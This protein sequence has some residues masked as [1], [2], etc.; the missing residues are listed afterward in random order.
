MST[1]ASPRLLPLQLWEV[2]KTAASRV[3]EIADDEAASM[4]LA[5]GSLSEDK[6]LAAYVSIPWKKLYAA[7]EAYGETVRPL[8]AAM[9][10]PFHPSPKITSDQRL[11]R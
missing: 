10:I 8:L 11:S 1:Q 9:A 6:L 5:H 3:I 4:I 2:R 7:Q